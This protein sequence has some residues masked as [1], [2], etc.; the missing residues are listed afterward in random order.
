MKWL[1]ALICAIVAFVL[2]A[3]GISG[4][5]SFMSGQIEVW[6]E[7]DFALGIPPRLMVSLHMFLVKTK[8]LLMPLLFVICLA[9]FLMIA[10]K[11]K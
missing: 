10:A 6:S 9:V 8:L 4:Y 2:L 1:V 5:N 11:K 7:S 3:V